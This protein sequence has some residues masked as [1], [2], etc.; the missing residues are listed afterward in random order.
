M[1]KINSLIQVSSKNH[2]LFFDHC[3][4]RAEGIRKKLVKVSHLMQVISQCQWEMKGLLA[5]INLLQEDTIIAIE[6]S[7]EKEGFY[8]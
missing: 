7:K 2:N 4:D 8:E 3:A 5:E 1:Q 6:E